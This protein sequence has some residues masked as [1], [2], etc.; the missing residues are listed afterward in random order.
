VPNFLESTVL[1]STVSWSDLPKV[2]DLILQDGWCYVSVGA[3]ACV[4][5][6]GS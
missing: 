6:Q 5:L 1:E 2:A 4:V 3:L